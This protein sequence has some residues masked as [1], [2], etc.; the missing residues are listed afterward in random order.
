MANARQ[1]KTKIGPRFLAALWVGKA[2]AAFARLVAPSKGSN[3]P[4]ELA[5]KLAPDMLTGFRG[6]DFEKAVFITGTNG[7]STSTNLLAHI[8]R[9]AGRSVCANLEGANLKAGVCTALLK[10]ATAGG[11]LKDEWLILEVDERSLAAIR[12]ALPAKNLCVTNLQKDQVQRNGDPDYIYQKVKAAI[13]PDVTVYVN[14]EEPRSKSLERFA[15]TAVRFGVA[16]PVFRRED[17]A[18]AE[19]PF[20]VTMPCPVCHDALDFGGYHLAN[21]GPFSCPSCGFASEAAGDFVIENVDAEARTF[22][23]D[24]AAYPMPYTAAH[25]L[26]NYALA[27]AVALSNGIAPADIARALATFENIGGRFETF[28]LADKTVSYVRMKQENP[29]TLQSALDVIAADPREK[30]FL[31]GLDVVDD[32][33]PAYSN[34]FYAYDCDFSAVARGVEKIICFG[35]TVCYDVALRLRYAG[36]PDERVEIYETGDED[37]ILRAAAACKSQAVYLI[38]LLKKF[39]KLRAHAG[40]AV[41]E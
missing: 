20:A 29:E 12:A 11:R 13:A 32:I 26:Y 16:A 6:I 2:A 15:G 14:N 17:G 8:F 18:R 19:D 23:I 27:S 10:R 24:G 5:L 37:A 25:F 39:E 41:H 9:T 36:V 3:L 7:K 34:T 33:V 40:V 1:E 35:E 4:G 38:T 21:V 28:A 30:V 31:V 22:T